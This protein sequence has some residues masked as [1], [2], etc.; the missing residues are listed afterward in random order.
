MG[1]LGF[2]YDQGWIRGDLTVDLSSNSKVKASRRGTDGIAVPSDYRC[3]SDASCL[4]EERVELS[5]LTTFLNVYADIGQWNGLSPYVGVGL[6]AA[7]VDWSDHRTTQTCHS[8]TGGCIPG[9]ADT[10]EN[11]DPIIK[12]WRQDDSSDWRLAWALM[13]G[14]SYSLDEN[15]S[16]DIGYRYTRIEDG[17][18]LSNVR[19]TAEG[20]LGK[21]E[22][23]DLQNHEIRAGLR[24]T[25]AT[26]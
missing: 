2:G 19:G 10:A 20:G 25:L 9:Y 16:V 7:Y 22:Y 8:S 24:Y 4:A 14:V 15:L 11:I 23:E 26:D 1:G 13:A 21:I 3:E 18:V 5:T 12:S 6:G 17:S